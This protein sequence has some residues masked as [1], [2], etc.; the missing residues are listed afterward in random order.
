MKWMSELLLPVSRGKPGKIRDRGLGRIVQGGYALWNPNDGTVILTPMGKELYSR[1]AKFL[2][3]A[4]SGF[5]PQPIDTCG[6]SRGALDAAVRVV[7]RAGDLPLLLAE[8]TRDRLM[9]LGLHSDA[10]AAMEMCSDA[11]R[12]TGSAVCAFDVRLRRADRLLETGYAIDLCAR[13]E[14]PMRGENGFACPD[15]GWLGFADTPCRHDGEELAKSEPAE[16]TLTPTPDCSTIEDLCAF[17]GISPAQTVKCMIYAVEGRGLVA[18]I[19]RGDRQVSLEKVRAALG[20][21][22][23]RPAERSELAVAMGDSAGYMGPVGL[24]A[25]VTLLADASVPGVQNVVV[26]ANKAGY[27]YTGACWGRDFETSSVFDLALVQEG[28]R[29]PVCGSPLKV[30][31]LR[32]VARFHPVDPVCAAEPSLTFFNGQRKAHVPAWS[33]E[34][35]LTAFLSAVTESCDTLPRELAPFDTFVCWDGDEAPAALSRVIEALEGRGLS[36]V[37]DDRGGKAADRKAEAAALMAPQ[38]VRFSAGDT[39]A[40]TVT[41]N[42]ASH[43][44]EI[45]AFTA[46]PEA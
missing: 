45:E 27:H 9:L 44:Y 40:L 11:L 22:A 4:L 28:D 18:V 19:L 25:A 3:N 8:R 6:S 36:V 31:E 21:V 29:C 12:A 7:R 23:V 32:R 46:S 24:P 38:T 33:A 30:A 37:A 39:P 43:E 14:T 42:G 10:E 1:A 34:L 2:L 35:D 16:L 26:G 5:N 15:C 17:F 20:G 41:E 13:T